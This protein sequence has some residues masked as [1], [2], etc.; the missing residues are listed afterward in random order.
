MGNKG[1]L[2]NYDDGRH[3]PPL[4]RFFRGW[5]KPRTYRRGGVRFPVFPMSQG[6]LRRN[7][8]WCGKFLSIVAVAIPLVVWT[9]VSRYRVSIDAAGVVMTGVFSVAFGALGWALLTGRP[10]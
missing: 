3:P 2:F 7:A 4:D 6:E 10:R 1:R 5:G 9:L 8:R